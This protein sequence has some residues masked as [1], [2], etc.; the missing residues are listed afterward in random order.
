VPHAGAVNRTRTVGLVVAAVATV[1]WLSFLAA[2]LT[3]D[4]DDGA[5]IG[6]GLAALLAIP[7]SVASSVVLLVSLR[8]RS[9]GQDAPGAVRSRR[10]PERLAA[11]L[12]AVSVAALLTFLFLDPYSTSAVP[13][14]T[15][16]AVGVAAFLASAGTFAGATRRRV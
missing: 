1:V 5:N 11:A 12:S 14:V 10:A 16:L 7:L 3:A 9:P 8:T 15:T 6:A 4:P 13:R 2:I